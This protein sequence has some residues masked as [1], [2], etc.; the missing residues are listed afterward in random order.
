MRSKGL[1]G[2]LAG[3]AILTALDRFSK[4]V[5]NAASRSAVGGFLTSYDGDAPAFSLFS[6]VCEKLGLVRGISIPVKRAIGGACERSLV[7]R[8]VRKIVRLGLHISVQVY[9]IGLFSAG[10]YT[11][12]MYLITRFALGNADADILSLFIGTACAIV[13]VPLMFSTQPLGEA[14]A[15]S[16]LGSFIFITVLGFRRE[17][18]C[19]DAPAVGKNTVAFVAGILIGLSTYFISPLYMLA[20]TF[21]L[22][23]AYMLLSMPEIGVLALIAAL[24][25]LPTMIIAGLTVVT[26]VCYFLKFIRG[27]RVLR[28]ELLDVTVLIF[29]LFTL[30][31]GV[32]SINRALSLKPGLLYVCFIAGYFLVVNLIRTPE[33]SSRCIFAL[34]LSAFAVAA[35]GVY[36][37]FFGQLSLTWIDAEMFEDIEGRVVS[38]FANPNVLAEYLILTF[39][40]ALSTLLS[41]RR[42]AARLASLI[43]TG[44]SALCLIYTWS[45]GAWLG[46]M[47][48]LLVFFLI[49]SRRTVMVLSFG[50]LAVPFLPLVLPSTV[51]TR[52]TSIGN[53]ADTSTAYR[54]HIWMGSLDMARDVLFSGLGSG[55]GVFAAVYPQYSLGGI[56]AAPHSHNL[57][58]QLVIEL[59]IFGL[60]AFLLAMVSFTRSVLSCRTRDTVTDR[61]QYLL[62]AAG[63][64]AIIAFL[65]QGMTDYVWYNYRIYAMFWLVLGLT[66]AV[67][68]LVAAENTAETCEL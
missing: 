50:L 55:M 65:A 3:S 45:R 15:V 40:F 32:F 26:A 31:G 8:A 38:T 10:M 30:C 46:L 53:L 1:R 17:V 54:V 57:Y 21:A 58:L 22:I 14:I 47:L 29:M 68:R 62:A 52:F 28:F 11:A 42:P 23:A 64:C 44:T 37:N 43:A 67:A 13:S 35:I 24:P 9:G 34:M 36:E 56:E 25:F 49:Y 27:K 7:M 61:S 4:A 2:A 33:W 41:A 51:V 48:A 12:I 66:S 6:W 60:V 16:R 20:G 59:G 19:D 5:Y 39:P 63:L 18:I